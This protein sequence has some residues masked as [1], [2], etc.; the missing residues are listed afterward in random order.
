MKTSE[1]DFELPQEVI[2]KTIAKYKEAFEML[3]GKEFK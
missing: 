2:D 1:F 3:T